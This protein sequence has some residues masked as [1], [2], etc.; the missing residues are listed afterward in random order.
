MDMH[1]DGLNTEGM[2]LLAQSIPPCLQ[3]LKLRLRGSSITDDDLK[4]FAE[5]LPRHLKSI[6]MDLTYCKYISSEGRAAFVATLEAAGSKACIDLDLRETEALRYI[7]E[8]EQP[9]RDMVKALGVSFYVS[10]EELHKYSHQ[11]VPAVPAL[12]KTLTT[13]PKAHVRRAAIRALA[14]FGERA[15]HA[16]AALE[17]ASVEDPDNQKVAQLALAKIRGTEQPL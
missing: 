13:E 8:C 5:C 1:L 16:V 6:S 15:S 17:K 2:D 10:E 3:D 11:V 12:L 14:S 4:A 9:K 7:M